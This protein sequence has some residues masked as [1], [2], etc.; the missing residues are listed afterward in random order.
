MLMAYRPCHRKYWWA[1]QRSIAPTDESVHLT[2]GAALAKG[3]EVTRK[4]YFDSNLSFGDSIAL[5]GAALLASYGPFEPN[6]IHSN[7][8]ALATLGALGYYFETWP[9]DSILTPFKPP[10]EHKHAIEYSFAAP[11]AGTAHP[12]T[13]DP[14]IYCGRFDMI[15]IYKDT[16][17]VGE[18]DKTASQLGQQWLNRWKL[19]NQLLG[20]TWGCAQHGIKLGGFNVRGIGL[21]KGSYNSLESL[22]PIPN[23][24]LELFED[25]LRATLSSMLQAWE[26]NQWD[27]DLGHSCTLYG[28][29][30]FLLLCDSPT[31][32]DWIPI[33]YVPHAW[34]PLASRD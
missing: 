5:G 32:E 2:A 13:G 22:Q 21:L 17:L 1:H 19:S 12:V 24:K 30:P 9:I 15:G 10:G 16:M 26:A 3:L 29:C 28:G 20:Y 18:D 4:S 8:N 34:D 7:K 11:I 31:P 6:L 14:I 23:W 25:Q 27:M 33:N